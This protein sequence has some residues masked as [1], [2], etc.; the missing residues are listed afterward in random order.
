MG[1]VYFF[2]L[3]RSTFHLLHFVGIVNRKIPYKEAER[4]S[5]PSSGYT[6]PAS[7]VCE[8]SNFSFAKMFKFLLLASWELSQTGNKLTTNK[9]SSSSSTALV[10]SESGADKEFTPISSA[11]I[12]LGKDA[13]IEDSSL[14]VSSYNHYKLYS[15]PE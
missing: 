9:F 5:V 7:V 12:P 15:D 3:W 1:L 4:A 11:S 13:V 6:V 10:R 8:C 2:G 14:L